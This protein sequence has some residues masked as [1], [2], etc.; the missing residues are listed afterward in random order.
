MRTAGR[1]PPWMVTRPTPATS[2]KRWVNMVSV[3]SLSCRSEIDGD[4]I[5]SVMIGESAGLTLA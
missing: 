5:A 2:L 4:V 3:R 1:M